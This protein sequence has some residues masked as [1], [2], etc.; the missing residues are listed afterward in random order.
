MT[1][2]AGYVGEL[3][4]GRAIFTSESI[5]SPSLETAILPLY[6]QAIP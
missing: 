5:L 2:Q 6:N 3:G 1:M 4:H